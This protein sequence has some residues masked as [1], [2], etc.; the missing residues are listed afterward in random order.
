VLAPILESFRSSHPSVAIMMHTGDQADGVAR[1][2]SG[3]DDLAVIARPTVLPPRLAFLPL[4]E[5][6]LILC[7]P[8]A[9]CA[10]RDLID[11][12]DTYSPDYDWSSAAIYCA[13]AGYQQGYFGQLVSRPGY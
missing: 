4:R 7:A 6:A 5:S 12:G 9:A 10:V 11:R 1:V 3:Q 13:R 2:L 8:V